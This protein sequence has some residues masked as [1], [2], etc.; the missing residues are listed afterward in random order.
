MERR[1][2]HPQY[3]AGLVM[4]T[5]HGEFELLVQFRDGNFRWVRRDEL[6]NSQTRQLNQKTIRPN[7]RKHPRE[8]ELPFAVSSQSS[9]VDQS[10]WARKM[11]EAFR[12]GIVP[13]GDIEDF[14][15]GRQTESDALEECLQGEKKN[16]IL[17]VGEYGI[18]KTHFLEHAYIKA[19]NQ[20]FAVAM[21]DVDPS[22][23]PF[24]KPKRVYRRL[25]QT[26]R[27]KSTQDNQFGDFRSFVKKSIAKGAFAEHLYFRELTGFG[28]DEIL[29][30]WLEASESAIRPAEKHKRYRQLPSL[31]DHA[32]T[33]NIYCYLLSGL[34]W[35]AREVMGLNGLVL[36]FDESE[37]L[38]SQAVYK[39]HFEKGFDFF[40]ALIFTSNNDERLSGSPSETG[41]HYCSMGIAASIPFMYQKSSYLKPIFAFTSLDWLRY[42]DEIIQRIDLRPLAEDSLQQI[43]D[44]I[45]ELY[46]QAYYGFTTDALSVETILAKI[47]PHSGRT[48]LFVKACVEALDIIRNNP[49][50]AIDE[51]LQ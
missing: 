48:R 12:L 27:Y 24:H 15:F 51:L 2:K 36:I 11:I 3:G 4:D 1:V 17:V 35:A 6:E 20:G 21:V 7:V 40:K 47:P 49:Y 25:A 29:W 28:A 23:T 31:Y 46:S 8:I 22:E 41:L 30:S 43:L 9:I 34:G 50:I 33:G 10:L 26:F 14:T 5:R 13:H 19:L 39:S 38:V 16:T 32:N 44:H 42:P 45:K 37:S 18:G